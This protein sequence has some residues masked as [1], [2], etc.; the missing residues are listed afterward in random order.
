MQPCSL[1]CCIS[2]KKLGLSTRQTP[3]LLISKVVH[4]MP[5][6]L[7]GGI[8]AINSAI[9]PPAPIPLPLH[10]PLIFKIHRTVR[11]GIVGV[12]KQ[13][14]SANPLLGEITLI[15]LT[16]EMALPSRF[17]DY[18]A[19]LP[20]L[21]PLVSVSSCPYSTPPSCQKAACATQIFQPSSGPFMPVVCFPCRPSLS[22]PALPV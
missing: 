10:F 21:L 20:S 19:P 13:T 3:Y 15:G 4:R 7:P 16:D 12:G 1:S 18:L 14:I 2:L 22:C 8:P 17:R 5:P 6:F 11:E 9:S